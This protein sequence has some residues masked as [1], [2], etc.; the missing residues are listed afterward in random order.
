MTTDPLIPCAPGTAEPIATSPLRVAASL[1]LPL[2]TDTEPPTTTPAP[3]VNTT[4]PPDEGPAESPPITRTVPAA[5]PPPAVVA[6]D[7]PPRTVTS[8]AIELLLEPP[9]THTLPPV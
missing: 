2:L 6:I 8:P 9:L 7:L 1:P 5:C 4:E 3:P